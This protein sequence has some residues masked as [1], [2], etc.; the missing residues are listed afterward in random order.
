MSIRTGS[1][2]FLH[3]IYWSRKLDTERGGGI[4]KNKV[5]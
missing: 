2:R 3:L 5:S 1:E 4:R